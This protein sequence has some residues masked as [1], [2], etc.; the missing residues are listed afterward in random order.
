MTNPSIV[1]VPGAWHR[2]AHFQGLIDE[3]AKVDYDAEAVTMPSVDSS[4]PLASWDQDAQAVR[5]VIMTKLDAGKDVVVLAHSFGGV[6]MSEGAKGLGKKERDSQGLKGGIIKLVYM[7]AMALP[8]GQTH[9]GQLVPQTPEEEEIERQRK[10]M[11]VQFGGLEVTADGAIVLPKDRIHLVFYNRCDQKDIDRAVGLLGTFPMGPLIVPAT[12]TAYREIPSTYIVCKN[13]LALREPFQ[14]RMIAQGEGCFEVEECEEGH[15]PFMMDATSACSY[16]VDTECRGTSILQRRQHLP[17]I[18]RGVKT[19]AVIHAGVPSDAVLCSP[20]QTEFP[21]RSA[22]IAGVSDA[23]KRQ[24]RRYGESSVAT[25]QH[26]S[27]DF[28]TPIEDIAGSP[29]NGFD[30]TSVADQDVLAAW[31]NLDYDEIVADSVNAFSTNIEP[32]NSSTAL[33]PGSIAPTETQCEGQGQ[34]TASTSELTRLHDGRSIGSNHRPTVGLSFSSP[35]HLLNSGI[36][37]KIFGDRLARIYE[38]IATASAS[39]FLDYDCNLYATGSRYR[40][41]DHESGSSNGSAPPRSTVDSTAISPRYALS[42]SSQ[43]LPYEISLL[44][45][46]RFLDHLGD[47]YGNRLNST[48]RKKSDETFKAV[49]RAFSMQWLPSSPSFGASSGY[50]HFPRNSKSG[51]AG[52]DSSL[53]AFI[54]AW[55]QARSL[56]RDAHDVRSFRVVLSTLMFV[57]IVTPTKITDGADLVPNHFLDTALQK[58]SYLDGLVTQY[59]AN[60]GPSST[61]SALAE[62]SLSIV[63]WTA[64]IRDTGAALAMDRQC[65]L[66]DIW[67]TTKVFSNKESVTALAVSRNILELDINVQPICRKASAETFCVWRQIIKIKAVASQAHGTINERSLST[68]EAIKLSVAAVRDFSESFQPFIL[69]CIKNFHCL[70][71][72]PRISLVSLVMFWNLGIFL[73]AEVF[74]KVTEDL[75]PSVDQDIWSAVRDYQRDAASCV[76]QVVECVLNLPA[77]EAFNLQ[78]GLGAE[79]PLTAYHVTP[80]LAVTALQRAIESVIDLQLH[81]NCDA[82][83]LE[84]NAQ[85]LIPDGIWDRQIDILMKGL[86]SLD[87]TIGGSQTCGVALGELMRNHGDVLSECWTSGFES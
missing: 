3:L 17:S 47:L 5:Q 29:S 20:V 85:F 40:L 11:E 31:L 54:D 19:Q 39:R 79:V 70:S 32:S 10:E 1:I 60:L 14:R 6:A 24:K 33:R 2:P 30:P 9:I 66:P 51:E 16:H 82:G 45:S 81:S 52:D 76:T 4:P 49:L 56:L 35:I 44:G 8:E 71:T 21:M 48:A 27:N 72:C 13:D 26:E 15:S 77:E 38:A 12:Y 78:N 62:A 25:T 64:Y 37:A 84:D 43:A 68:I 58:L 46:V 53:D 23:N 18:H 7:C 34:L 36:D 80:S 87:V 65:K 69:H 63:R 59:C 75:D 22:Q 67:G 73:L 41:G 86:M 74:K 83:A 28:D 42:V 50:A 57:G 55:V 61:Y